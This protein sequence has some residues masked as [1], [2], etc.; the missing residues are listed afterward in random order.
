M[1]S[2]IKRDY[3]LKYILDKFNVNTQDVD[4]LMGRDGMPLY[5]PISQEASQGDPNQFE[6]INEETY[7]YTKKQYVP[8]SVLVATSDFS[9][10]TTIEQD[11][12]VTSSSWSAVVEFLVFAGSFVHNKIVFAMEEFRDKFFGKIDFMEG[13][14]WDYDTPSVKASK[15]YY[16]VVTHCSDLNPGGIVT[17]NGDIYMSYTFDIDLDI[18]DELAYGNQFEFYVKELVGDTYERVLPIVGSW[19]S[20]NS[21]KGVQLLKNT[22]LSGDDLSKAKQIHNLVT[23]RGFNLNF[24]F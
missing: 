19:G 20:S 15:K 9:N 6:F 5:Q 23:S 2:N 4:F 24:T 12:R 3:V 18:S 1:K 21:L 17:I 8:V 14:E 13:R 7:Q 10:L 11:K 22:A 16:N